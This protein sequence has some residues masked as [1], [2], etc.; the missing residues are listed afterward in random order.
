MMV[1]RLLLVLCFSLL[2]AGCDAAASLLAEP[3]PTPRPTPTADELA[4]R[5]SRLAPREGLPSG[6]RFESGRY[7]PNTQLIPQ[8]PD[9]AT[10]QE[11]LQ[12]WGRITGYI[13]TYAPL[14]IVEGKGF[15]VSIDL[16]E[17]A[18]GARSAFSTGPTAPTGGFI[19]RQAVTLLGDESLGFRLR[20]NA[21]AIVFHSF[22]LRKANLTAAVYSQGLEPDPDAATEAIART[23]LTRLEAELR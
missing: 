1:G 23:A 17:T 15:Q 6:Y 2:A 8:A 9:P 4:L 7:E 11:L 21:G 20:D 10:T 14:D 13:A 5:L 16:Y 3:T 18:G 19:D 22:W 12:R